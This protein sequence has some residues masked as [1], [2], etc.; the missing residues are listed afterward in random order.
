MACASRLSGLD[1]AM[2]MAL[3][4]PFLSKR[5][6]F[7]VYKDGR[8]KYPVSPKEIYLPVID[9]LPVYQ[10]SAMGEEAD[11]VI[12]SLVAGDLLKR[13]SLMVVTIDSDLLHL[14]DS[15]NVV[16]INSRDFSQWKHRDELKN[17]KLNHIPAYKAIFGDQSDNVKPIWPR[18][19]KKLFEE[20][21]WLRSRTRA[22]LIESCT[23][24]LRDKLSFNEDQISAARAKLA[25]NYE[26]VY[27]K[28]DLNVTLTAPNNCK[29]QELAKIHPSLVFLSNFFSGGAITEPP[30][31]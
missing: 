26:L 10:A 18:L 8:A 6:T 19:N 2:V 30:I 11:D 16:L 28:F 23:A 14:A 13:K 9:K 5:A 17:Y 3:D 25:E 31:I 1:V 24:V 20:T 7:P 29:P 22:E 21:I 12:C 15:D 4:S 27:P